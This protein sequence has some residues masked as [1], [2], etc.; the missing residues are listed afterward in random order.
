MQKGICS[1]FFPHL[2][3]FCNMEHES[4][5]LLLVTSLHQI[6]VVYSTDL[7]KKSKQTEMK[8]QLITSKWQNNCMHQC[9]QSDTSVGNQCLELHTSVQ[10]SDTGVYNGMLVSIIRLQ[11]LKQDTCVTVFVRFF[12][13]FS[14]FQHVLP[15]A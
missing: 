5:V 1:F 2:K 15:G 10:K 14:A 3:K 12:L 8:L 6:L 13:L 4:P 9:L 7:N 11:L